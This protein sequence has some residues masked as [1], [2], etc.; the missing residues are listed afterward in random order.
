MRQHW[1]IIRKGGEKKHVIQGTN[2]AG[3]DARHDGR[4]EMDES[5]ILLRDSFYFGD[6]ESG[7]G[8]SQLAILNRIGA[9]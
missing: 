1:C 3:H 5:A 9:S 2:K 6:R 4:E 8:R 7:D